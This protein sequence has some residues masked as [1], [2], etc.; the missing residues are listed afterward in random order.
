MT[1]ILVVD[2]SSTDRR[3]VC[4]LLKANT[5]WIVSEASSGSEALQMIALNPVN[6]VLTDLAMPDISG[7]ELV[8]TLRRDCPRLPVVIMTGV[9]TDEIAVTA[10]KLGASSYV[11]KCRLAQDLTDAIQGVLDAVRDDTTRE[12]LSQRIVHHKIEFCIENDPELIA[13]LVQYLQEETAR[14][15]IC[16]P[17][18]RIRVGVAL[19]EAMTNACYHGNLEVSSSLREIDHRQ[20]Y[21]L[22]RSR[23]GISPYQ[24]RRIHVAAEFSPAAAC[25]VIRD[26]G[27]GFDPGTIPDPTVPDNLEKP[28]GRGLLLIQMFMD[29]VEY[30]KQGNQ[31][32]LKKYRREHLGNS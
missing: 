25:F 24:E 4:G 31:V 17:A 29:E 30:S 14:S 5:Q 1:G 9:G 26:E 6:V 21:E 7:L 8:T 12:R 27:P 15:G 10:L 3:L 23:M 16:E 2:D 19:Q 32:V 11:P 22:A 13:S 28:C 20:F 18:D